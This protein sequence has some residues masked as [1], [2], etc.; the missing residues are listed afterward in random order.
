MV[1]GKH[2]SGGI[3]PFAGFSARDDILGDNPRATGGS[4]FAG[5]PAGCAAALKTLE[6]I[7]RD[8]VLDHAQGLAE[9][10]AKAMAD[11]ETRF[12]I[13]S[14]V[15]GLGLLMAVSFQQPGQ[16][17]IHIARSV[18]DEMLR[19]GVWALCDFQP[20]V[21][22]YPALNMSAEVFKSGLAVMEAAIAAVAR[23]GPKVGDYPPLPSGNV[24]F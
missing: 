2:L 23:D 5:T 17:G 1:V 22:M 6:I 14:Q 21:R 18:R 7:R 8:Q 19:R 12:E 3:E 9:L 20:Q 11:W 13:V 24:G 10:A 15:R 16:N 4:T